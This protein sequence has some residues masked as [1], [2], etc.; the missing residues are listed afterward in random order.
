MVDLAA[1][2]LAVTPDALRS[3]GHYL[4]T[5]ADALHS[6]I[7]ELAGSQEGVAGANHGFAAAQ[8][9]ADCES[10][11]EQALTVFGTKIAVAGDNITLSAVTYGGTEYTNHQHFVPK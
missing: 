11:W 2:K 1:G 8:A 4:L 10:G 9:M 7:R 6:N 5:T 3:A